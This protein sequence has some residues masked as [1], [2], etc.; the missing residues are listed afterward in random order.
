MGL[1]ERIA[2]AIKQSG[3]SKADIARACGVTAASVTFWISGQTKS[4]KAETAL[5]LEQATGYR[6]NWLLSGTGPRM[7]GEPVLVWPFSR[8][9]V[10]RFL[11]LAD[12]DRGYVQRRLLQ[13][14]DE[15]E[16]PHRTG[17]ITPLDEKTIVRAPPARG[18]VKKRADR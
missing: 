8:V 3:K 4:L 5:A 10:S 2:E 11:A 15:C 13:A 12:D 1:S 7:V 9:P 14:I 18:K 17:E 16:G 6:A